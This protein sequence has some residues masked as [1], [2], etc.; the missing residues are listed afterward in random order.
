MTT[1]KSIQDR[2]K[3]SSK[4]IYIARINRVLDYIENN[5][6]KE[7]DLDLLS[8]I[9]G[10]SK[11]HFHRLFSVL[12][13]ETLNSFIKRLRI[14]KAA[15]MLIDNPKVSITTIALHCGFSSLQTFSRSFNEHFNMSASKFRNEGYKKVS[16]NSKT[17]SNKWKENITSF[18]YIQSKILKERRSYKMKAEVKVKSIPDLHVAY[19]RHIGPYKGNTKLFEELFG[20]LKK[21]AG[22]R[23]LLQFPK[24]KAIAVYHDDP[25]VTDEANLRLSICI[26]VPEDTEVDGEICKMV[27]PGGK[28]AVARFRLKADQYED[29]WQSLIGGWLPES[30]YQPDDRPCYEDYINDPK[31]HPRNIHIVDFY[32]P[33]KPL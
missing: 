19:I 33:V 9:A 20:K 8:K 16:K 10:F 23:G 25:K 27:I 2:Y 18:E 14:E 32:F 31:E 6:D 12:I 17:K 4:E 15:S 29:A 28:Y 22:P 3:Q 5:I 7:L 1:V 13:G 30:G 11:Y 21:W 26:T 24:T